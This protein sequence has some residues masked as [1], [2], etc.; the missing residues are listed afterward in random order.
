MAKVEIYTK[1]WCPYSVRAKKL[2]DRKG[3]HYREID[4][5]TLAR[6]DKHQITGAQIL[7]PVLGHYP[8]FTSAD[9]MKTGRCS[10]LEF[11][12]P[13]RLQVIAE[14]DAALQAHRP[15]DF[16]QYFHSV[17]LVLKNSIIIDDR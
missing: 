10:V 9:Q 17:R 1:T 11:H 7:G 8:A 4:V 5:T 6:L 16:A 14:I 12:G 3:V 2:L 15:Q 13:R